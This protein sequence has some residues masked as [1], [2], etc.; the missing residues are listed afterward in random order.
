LFQAPVLWHKELNPAAFE[1]R[2][3]LPLKIDLMETSRLDPDEVP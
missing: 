3:G 1:L 2:K